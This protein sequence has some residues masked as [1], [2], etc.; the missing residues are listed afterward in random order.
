M[1]AVASMLYLDYGRKDGEWVANIYG[2][3]ENLEAIEMIKHLNSIMKKRNP[4][5]LMIAEESTAWPKVTGALDDEGLGFDLKWNMGFM[6]DYLAYISYDPYFRA[7]HHNEL[8]FSM[9]YAYS[10]NFMLPFSHDEV[11]HGKSSM[12]GKMPGTIED[13]FANLRLTY[14][15]VMTHPGKK[16]LF[17]GQDIA[18]FQEFDETR[19]T[20]WELLKEP[21]H[22]G[23]HDLVRDLN[24]LY[25]E[26]PALYEKDTEA[27][28]FQW[29]NCISPEKC[30]LSYMR[31][32]LKPE[33]TL[34]VVA[35]FANIEQEFCI[36]V[37]MAGK[38]KE[39]L[40][41]D[42]KAYGGKGLVNARAIPV[43]DEEYDGQPCSF[44]MKAAPLSLSIFKFVAYTAKEK[45]QIENRKAETKA[46]RLAQEAGQRAKEAEAEA[47]ELTLRAKELKKQAEEIMQQAQKALQRAKEEEKLASIE[48]KK[49]EEAAKKAK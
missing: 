4:D 24:H 47:E 11:V 3:N 19:Q 49:A 16:L 23:I 48:W 31:K 14:G 41:T 13:K 9:I 7:H 17:M 42:D 44:T 33:Q 35:N 36:G 8:T 32:A 30:M 20:K 1:D 6:N 39:I 37:P 40:N 5:V 43:N 25:Q 22:K 15:Y 46:I 28:G 29:I 26:L 38:Y 2:G 45:Q 18:E 12:I 27:D 34:V 21:A 10:E